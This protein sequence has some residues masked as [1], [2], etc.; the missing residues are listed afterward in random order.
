MRASLNG[1]L[2]WLQGY[3]FASRRINQGAFAVVQ[4]GDLEGIPVSLS[5]QVLATTNRHGMALVTGLLPYQANELTLNPD[6]LPFDVEVRGVRE[7]VTPYARSGVVVDF[8]V[9]RSRDALVVLQQADGAIV[10]TGARVVVT[11]GNQEFVVGR[12]GEAYLMDLQ[13]DNL[14]EVRWG[15]GSCRLP[16]PLGPAQPGEA[17]PRIGPLICGGRP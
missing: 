5:N 2:G 3:S 4:V 11:P 16:L 1:S 6:Q 8:P 15:G 7:T 12:R 10:P 13:D 9:K 14:I 17:P